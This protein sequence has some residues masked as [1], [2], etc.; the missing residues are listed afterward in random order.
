[1]SQ[2]LITKPI[3]NVLVVEN[4]S[5]C[6]L[7][8]SGVLDSSPERAH[9]RV[10][11]ILWA[12]GY[13]DGIEKLVKHPVDVLLVDFDLAPHEGLA[14]LDAAAQMGSRAPVILLCRNVDNG[15]GIKAISGGATECIDKDALDPLIV[16]RSIQYALVRKRA[17]EGHTI[18]KVESHSIFDSVPGIV[19]TTEV[20]LL[21]GRWLN[22]WKVT[23]R[24]IN[25]AQWLVPIT[26]PPGGNY[27]QAFHDA[28]FPEDMIQIA[29]VV[30][31]AILSG[32][33]GYKL[34][35]RVRKSNGDVCWICEDSRIESVGAGRWRL[36]GVF[37]DIT[38]RKEAEALF[39]QADLQRAAIVRVA[40]DAIIVMNQSG[41]IVEFNPAAEAMF[42][43]DRESAIGESL[44][45]LVIPP[46]LREQHLAG[47]SLFLETGHGPVLNKRIELVG[48]RANASQFPVEVA[49]TPV[50]LQDETLFIGFVRDITDRVAAETESLAQSKRLES[51]RTRLAHAQSLAHTG[52]WSFDVATQTLSISEEL[53]RLA[54]H[55][56]QAFDVT[57]DSLFEFFFWEDWPL[58]CASDM[59]DAGENSPPPD[60]IVRI[61]RPNGEVRYMLSRTRAS[62][63]SDGERERIYGTLADITDR[64]VAEQVLERFFTM[65]L[66][67]LSIASTDGYFKRMNPAFETTLGFTVDELMSEPSISFVHPEDRAR[68]IQTMVDLESGTEV[69]Q[70]I[71]RFRCRDGSYRWF[72]WMAAPFGDQIYSVAHDITRIKEAEEELL[73]LNAELEL[74]VEQRT[75]DLAI[76]KEQAD[77]AN[78]A[79]SEFLS[80]M[81]HELRTPLNSIIGFGQ[82]LERRELDSMTKESAHYILKSGRHLLEL[83]NEVLDLARLEAGHFDV[84]IEP[85][86]LETLVGECLQLVGVLADEKKISVQAHCSQDNSVI[87]L[88]DQRRLKQVLINLLSNG[89]KYN[90]PNGRVEIEWDPAT[91]LGVQIR[92]KDTG[93]GIRA[94]HL[95]KLF[96]PFER[97]G[98]GQ[99]SVEG[100]GLGLSLSH[101]LVTLMGGSL[102]VESEFGI[103][104]TFSIL[105][106]EAP[107]ATLLTPDSFVQSLVPPHDL[108]HPIHRKILYIDDNILN[109]R[110]LESITSNLPHTTL[111]TALDG[112][113]GIE[114]ALHQSPDLIL[115]DLNLPDVSGLQVLEGLRN[116]T[117][118]R[119]LPII[120]VSADASKSQINNLLAAGANDY[121]TKPFDLAHLTS[122]IEEALW[123]K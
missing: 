45:N 14:F 81:S 34:E 53:F 94:E 28:K 98:A 27:A 79:K 80:R 74:R 84:S 95:Q 60:H 9:A 12:V 10:K 56:P 4:S 120:V 11:A 117:E 119:S 90:R 36:T 122:V 67:M 5:D 40:L 29:P 85:V 96:K 103:G 114:M 24:N 64:W 89:I 55:E 41:Q 37:T 65:S 77:Q 15:S 25:A 62:Y 68:T 118:L 86:E 78:E 73:L 101:K 49:I 83:V 72:S 105:L 30:E 99:S 23:I 17:I 21:D 111:L 112:Q 76:A 121:F 51:E 26:I 61:R 87:V 115:L 47:L 54:G 18:S 44:A 92:I 70:F 8:Q 57:W 2:D 50:Q 102:S 35:Y 32:K 107:K 113:T 66:D 75:R 116:R 1:M 69:R 42:N 19:K 63:G 3:L 20:K 31:D 71:N 110:L 100:T 82:I 52:S 109:I 93:I 97:L 6:T 58:V 106:P 46:D 39:H 43:Y 33:P 38:E 7:Q 108:S 59:F 13:E 91:D 22:F 123:P 88:A 48:M 104:S 16:E